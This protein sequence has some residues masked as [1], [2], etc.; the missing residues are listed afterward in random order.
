MK[1]KHSITQ[2]SLLQMNMQKKK[3]R[4]EWLGDQWQYNMLCAFVMLKM[5]MILLHFSYNFRPTKLKKWFCYTMHLLV[6][7]CLRLILYQ[8]PTINKK[9]KHTHTSHTPPNQTVLSLQELKSCLNTH[10]IIF[11]VGTFGTM[12]LKTDSRSAGWTGSV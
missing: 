6:L 7:S 12:P 1:S 8:S 11:L 3:K 5:V 10:P 2:S 9:G 4:T